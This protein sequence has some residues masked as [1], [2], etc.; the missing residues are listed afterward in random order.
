[1]KKLNWP[2][3]NAATPKLDVLAA[4]VPHDQHAIFFPSFKAMIQALDEADA[5]GTPLL[6]WLEPRSEEA[7]TRARYQKQLCLELDEM[8]RILGPTVISSVAMTGSD[9]YLRTGS[10]LAILFEAKS[11]AILK[12]TFIARQTAAKQRIPSAKSLDGE[13]EGVS[14]TAVVTEDRTISS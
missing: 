14:Y 9:P 7:L 8:S 10:D 6:Q 12:A 3:I 4:Y 13:I 5:G 1:M 2:L 11:A